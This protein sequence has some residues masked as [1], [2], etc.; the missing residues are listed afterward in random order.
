MIGDFFRENN[1][2]YDMQKL[3]MTPQ[4]IQ[5]YQKKIVQTSACKVFDLTNQAMAYAQGAIG[6]GII[7]NET[8]VRTE[9]TDEPLYES[10]ADT[11]ALTQIQPLKKSIL[12]Q[13]NFRD[14][15][16]Q[17]TSFRVGECVW[18]LNSYQNRSWLYVQGR[19]YAGWIRADRVGQC[20]FE[21]MRNYLT[22]KHFVTVIKPTDIFIE[23]IQLKVHFSMGSRLLRA[24]TACNQSEAELC[25]VS[26]RD[27]SGEV[28]SSVSVY[29]KSES[30]ICPVSVH[31]KLDFVEL[32]K[33]KYESKYILH[34]ESKYKLQYESKYKSQYELKY[35]QGLKFHEGYLP[36]TPANI[37][38]QAQKLLE[39]PYRWG[40]ADGG[41]DCSGMVVAVHDCFGLTL[42]R[43][44]SRMIYCP[45]YV[46]DLKGMNNEAKR[47]RILQA[48]PGSLIF[49]P[50]HVMIY[51]GMCQGR[52]YILH[53]LSRYRRRDGSE[54]PVRK[55]V[56][57]PLELT[58]LDGTGYIENITH[59]MDIS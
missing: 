37:L 36:M 33:P 52:P 45:R 13:Q 43:D 53:A 3:L 22:T 18:I 38:C 58:R 10:G 25:Q 4:E 7:V 19:N 48:S 27:Q 35:L 49:F 29:D 17:L 21:Q 26:V 32:F 16:R 24:S 30:V 56:L 15:V 31:G 54:C 47:R 57:T 6:F 51:A 42:P 46:V 2:L 1:H 59:L 28:V 39:T 8:N 44:S 11:D 23:N 40:N 9:P 50:G 34:H 5:S 41:L 14:D 55:C 12:G 20:S